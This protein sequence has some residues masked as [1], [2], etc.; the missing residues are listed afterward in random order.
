MGKIE[1]Y[2]DNSS[3]KQSRINL[4]KKCYYSV[5]CFY[6]NTLEK[7]TGDRP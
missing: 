7:N 3:G 2:Y 5:F 4:R 6:I 1:E